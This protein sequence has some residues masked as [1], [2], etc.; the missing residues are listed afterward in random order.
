MAGPMHP[1]ESLFQRESITLGTE[2]VG[3]VN[4][5][6]VVLLFDFVA[7]QVV[8]VQL[9]IVLIW[10]VWLGILDWFWMVIRDRVSVNRP[11]LYHGFSTHL[12]KA[13]SL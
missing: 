10:I 1:A 8:K 12:G 4:S 9:I 7:E 11:R 13:G 2:I 5:A 3:R 6:D